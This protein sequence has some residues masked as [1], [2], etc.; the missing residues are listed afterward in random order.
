M[1]DLFRALVENRKE[2][3]NALKS[4]NGEIEFEDAPFVLINDDEGD[5]YDCCVSQAR[6]NEDSEIELFIREDWVSD[7]DCLS[8]SA[9][10]V[11]E[12]IT[13][14]IFG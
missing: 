7:L 2:A 10:N 6:L 4:I 5:I 3:V 12:A 11:Y 9:N 8:T 13:T 14:Q 1:T